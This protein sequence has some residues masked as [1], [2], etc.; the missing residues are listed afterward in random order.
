M[1]AG[2][3]FGERKVALPGLGRRPGYWRT[4]RNSPVC[5]A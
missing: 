4:T 5:G 3:K 2:R 1:A